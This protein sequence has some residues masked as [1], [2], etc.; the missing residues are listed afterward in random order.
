MGKSWYDKNLVGPV[1]QWSYGAPIRK[2][3]AFDGSSGNG[4]I[5]TV[6]LFKVTGAVRAKITA[7][8]TED[9]AGDTATLE[10]GISGA[11]TSIIPQATATD[12]DA[13]DI[14]H[15]ATPDAKIEDE[16]VAAYKIIT[17]GSDVIA[18]VGTA[19]ITDGTIAFLCEWMP[20]TADGKVEAY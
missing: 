14:W 15:D 20:V 7:V 18:T 8:C 9:L 10:V 5:G 2:T 17:D 13:G 6:N 19:N 12:I 1:G 4:A 11:T 3:V 16:S